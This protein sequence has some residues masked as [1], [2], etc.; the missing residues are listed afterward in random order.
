M[1]DDEQLS[2]VE[3]GLPPAALK[4]GKPS[5]KVE[6]ARTARA[7]EETVVTF[8]NVTYSV[9]TARRRVL[10]LVQGVSGALRPGDLTAIL[11]PSGSGMYAHHHPHLLTSR[12]HAWLS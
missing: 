4:P 3:A 2:K 11:G 7:A 5:P 10:T 1:S 6:V 9:K 12:A 8:T